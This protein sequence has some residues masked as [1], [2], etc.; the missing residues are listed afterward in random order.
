MGRVRGADTVRADN[1][2]ALYCACVAAF[3]PP[4]TRPLSLLAA[5]SP[6]I[7]N[8]RGALQTKHF[9]LLGAATHSTFNRLAPCIVPPSGRWAIG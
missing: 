6:V 9:A 1:W 4:T 7:G 2:L 3:S 8:G 5:Y